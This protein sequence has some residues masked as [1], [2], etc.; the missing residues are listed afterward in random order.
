MF[1]YYSWL[2]DSSNTSLAK[3]HNSTILK[4]R[5]REPVLTWQTSGLTTTTK[6]SG[7]RLWCRCHDRVIVRLHPVHPMNVELCQTGTWSPCFFV[8]LQ[9][10]G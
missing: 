1:K 7:H 5:S 8:R 3:I 4:S 10:Q 9:L 2:S 6:Y